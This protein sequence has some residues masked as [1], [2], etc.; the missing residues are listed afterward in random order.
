M[1]A[2]EFHEQK[3]RSHL[4]P[5]LSL[6]RLLSLFASAIFPAVPAHAFSRPFLPPPPLPPY[7]KYKLFPT[8]PP[9]HL[10]PHRRISAGKPSSCVAQQRL[11]TYTRAR[12]RSCMLI[13]RGRGRGVIITGT[14]SNFPARKTGRPTREQQGRQPLNRA[15]FPAPPFAP[16][17]SLQRVDHT[18]RA[19]SDD[20][21]FSISFFRG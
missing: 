15:Y 21:K 5:S 17:D 3:P 4:L 14:H 19:S 6:S 12:A 2:L 16:E 10:V 7:G 11:T 18:L 13:L 8:N 20:A 1:R 9:P